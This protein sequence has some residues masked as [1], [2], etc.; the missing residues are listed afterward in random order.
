MQRVAR[1]KN[2]NATA[3]VAP[4]GSGAVDEQGAPEF[5]IKWF[6][7]AAE[8]PM[9][10]HGTLSAAVAL[11]ERHQVLPTQSVRFYNR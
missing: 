1:D 11:L 7:P 3:F 4:R 2:L 10:G 6:S 9:C 5:D 8:L